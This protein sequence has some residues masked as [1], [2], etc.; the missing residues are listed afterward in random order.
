MAGRGF[1]IPDDVRAVA[2]PV[3]GHRTV[4]QDGGYGM[5]VMDHA[6]RLVT[7]ILDRWRCR[8][9]NDGRPSAVSCAT[10]GD[11]MG[12]R[13]GK[14]GRIRPRRAHWRRFALI[15]PSVGGWAM[16]PVAVAVWYMALLLDERTLVAAAL[17]LTAAWGWIWS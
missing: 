7:E 16:I 3:L 4:L 6:R 12:I 14:A 17:T 8:A 10:R 15:R 9:P 11:M 5:A 2:V 13:R 1:V